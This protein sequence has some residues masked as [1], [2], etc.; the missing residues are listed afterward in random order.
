[1]ATTGIINK[2]AIA[3]EMGVLLKAAIIEAAE[4]LI[5][6]ALDK[7]ETRMRQRVAEFAIGTIKTNFDV[8]V[9]GEIVEIR[10]RQG[11]GVTP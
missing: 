1:M 2:Q 8:R 9:F 4:P 5:K 10:I 11:G 7:I 3:D 6:D